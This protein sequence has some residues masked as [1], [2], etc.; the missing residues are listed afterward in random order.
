MLRCT[1]F[2]MSSALA[3]CLGLSLSATPLGRSTLCSAGCS[4]SL[5]C[6]G[7]AGPLTAGAALV[8]SWCSCLVGATAGG[9]VPFLVGSTTG[10]AEAAFCNPLGPSLMPTGVSSNALPLGFSVTVGA[11]GA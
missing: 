9:G 2:A 3:C 6:D 10:C 4:V 11:T 1:T 5:N 7:A 8:G